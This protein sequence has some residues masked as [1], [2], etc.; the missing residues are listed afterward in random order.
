M[1]A[2]EENACAMKV[3]LRNDRTKSKETIKKHE[4]QSD[5]NIKIII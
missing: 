5:L 1:K 2:F 3:L 4:L